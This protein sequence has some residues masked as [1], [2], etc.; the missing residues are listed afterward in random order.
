MCV[1]VFVFLYVYECLSIFVCACRDGRVDMSKISNSNN[2][3]YNYTQ[4]KHKKTSRQ[5]NVLNY[6][7]KR[8]RK[9]EKKC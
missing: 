2:F 5:K 8:A 7:K 9:Y 6:M 4:T 3:V 1:C